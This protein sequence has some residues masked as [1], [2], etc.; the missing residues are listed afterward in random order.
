MSAESLIGSYGQFICGVEVY[1]PSQPLSLSKQS[2]T[3]PLSAKILCK[4]VLNG[5]RSLKY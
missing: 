5:H 1:P 2:I 4:S 3:S